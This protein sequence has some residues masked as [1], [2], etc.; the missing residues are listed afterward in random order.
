MTLRPGILKS[1]TILLGSVAIRS[2]AATTWGTANELG[3]T[4][5]IR[6]RKPRAARI[7]IDQARAASVRSNPDVAS[8]DHMIGG[9]IGFDRHW[10]LEP[11]VGA[12]Q[13]DEAVPPQH[14]G[15]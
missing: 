1:L 9:G 12:D 5:A 4:T 6:R 3:R 8:V 13:G 14:L 2:V 7:E 11:V 10:L 15:A